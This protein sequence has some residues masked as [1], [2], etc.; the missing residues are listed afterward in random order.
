MLSPVFIHACRLCFRWAQFPSLLIL[1]DIS[2]ICSKLF[3]FFF[4]KYGT[5]QPHSVSYYALVGTTISWF[6]LELI[7]KS[8]FCFSTR[9]WYARHR[10]KLSVLT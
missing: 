3:Q 9:L 1:L 2:G 4:I 10:I 7:V 6:N 8:S 5:F